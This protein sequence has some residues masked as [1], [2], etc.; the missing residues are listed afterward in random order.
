[1]LQP[2]SP[3]NQDRETGL[4]SA[5]A[6]IYFHIKVPY[7]RW[8]IF[9]SSTVTTEPVHLT[10]EKS[11]ALVM[12]LWFCICCHTTDFVCDMFFNHVFLYH[13]HILVFLVLVLPVFLVNIPLTQLT[14]YLSSTSV[15]HLLISFSCSCLVIT[16]PS[17]FIHPVLTHSSILHV[18]GGFCAFAAPS[19]FNF[20]VNKSFSFFFS[21]LSLSLCP[22]PLPDNV[23]SSCFTVCSHLWN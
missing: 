16:H 18:S 23:G 5:L 7:N 13:R 2:N 9:E 19:A 3:E 14:F 11:D 10:S 20:F 22:P 12:M 6:S 15:F 4:N 21:F 1:M 8:C 17:I